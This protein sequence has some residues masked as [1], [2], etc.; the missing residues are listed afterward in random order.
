LNMQPVEIENYMAG[1]SV[2]WYDMLFQNAFRQD[3]TV[4]L[5]GR[6][7]E[8]SYFMS[9]GYLDNE[10]IVVGDDFQTVRSRINLEGK[11]NDFLSVGMYTQ[12]ADRDESQVPVDWNLGRTLSPWGSEYDEEGFYK[13]RPNEEASGGNHPYYVPS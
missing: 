2:N 12:F 5:S 1:R 11:I 13:F 6:K 7:E 9:L 3:H 10:G 8:M 4:S